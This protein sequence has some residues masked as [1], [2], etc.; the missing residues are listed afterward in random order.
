MYKVILSFLMLIVVA[1]NVFSQNSKQIDTINPSVI[2]SLKFRN[3]SPGHISGRISDLAVNPKNHSEYYVAVSSG[4]VWKTVNNG[5]TFDPIFDDYGSFSMGCI[6]IDPNNASVLWLGTGENTHQRSVSYG[7]GI[8]KSVDAGKSWTNMGLKQSYQIGKIIVHPK[9]S[10]VVFVACEGSVWGPGGERGVYKT[11][12]GGKTWKRTLFVSDNTG[13]SN[14]DI[15]PKD[16]DIMYASAEQRRRSNATRIGG[17]PESSLWKSTDGGNNWYKIEKGLPAS[18]KGGMHIAVSPVDNNVIYAMVEA[19]KKEGGF[20]RS[21]DKGESW[22]KMSGYV[23]S[24]Q[25]YCEFYPSPFDVNKIYATETVSKFSI[26]GGKTWTPIGN[27]G[28]HVDD[29]T[30]W[31]DNQDEMHF[32][33]GT[34][35][36]LYET[37]DGGAHYNHKIIPVTQY[38]R[39]FADNSY[40]FYWVYGGTQDNSSMGAPSNTLYEDGISRAEWEITIGGDG[41]WQAVD[42]ENT[43]IVYSEYQYGNI[44]RYDKKS[45]EKLFVKPQE[46]END[47]LYKWHWDTPFII[48][49]Y[50]PHR[51]YIAGNYLFKSDDRGDS[52]QKISGDLSTGVDRNNWPVMDRYWGIDA[53]EKDVST[54]LYGTAVSL[55]ESPLKD[56]FLCVG[57]NDGALNITE[58][59]GKTWSKIRKI[60]DAPEFTFISDIE[61]SNFDENVIYVTLNNHK[62]FDF[63]PYIFK[64]T[65][66]GKTWKSIA[67]K[68]PANQPLHTVKQDFKK[69]E[70][71]FLGSEFGLYLTL[72]EGK[73]WIKMKS[74]LPTIPVRDITTQKNEEDLVIA[75]FG[76]GFYIL[77]DYSPLRNIQVDAKKDFVLF[78]PKDAQLYVEKDR[79]GYGF[80]SVIHFDSNEAFGARFT[81]YIKDE[82]KTL[83][84]KRSEKEKDLIKNKSKIPIPSLDELRKEAEEVAPY[85]VFIIKD[86]KGTEIR[87]LNT[88]IATGINRMTWDLR[89]SAPDP[90]GTTNGKFDNSS[91]GGKGLLVAEGNY[92]VSVLRWANSKFDTLALDKVFKVKSLNISNETM[93]DKSELAKFTEDTRNLY[94]NYSGLARQIEDTHTK[95]VNL[96]QLANNTPGTKIDIINKI[97]A[98]ELTLND[99]LWQFNGQTPPASSEERWPQPVPLND[100]LNYLY[101]THFG[102]TLPVTT[103]E[104]EAMK[105]LKNALPQIKEKLEKIIKIEIPEIEMYFDKINAPW[106]EGKNN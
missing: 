18:D 101:Y 10:N 15:D 28:R 49:K 55:A 102:S 92:S 54:S 87:K 81:Y 62:N 61:M 31:I 99:L 105:I 14:I 85:L 27:N 73:Q 68:L 104:K 42:P 58:N 78:D 65:D 35:G 84:Q 96:K 67:G 40:P 17:G 72:D 50:N 13:V 74:G 51:L 82:I 71:L 98:T 57:T 3:L 38:Y 33:I 95:I 83:K 20:Y 48:S 11:E 36:G 6:T 1:I 91:T 2:G 8:Y 94:R 45:G 34:D 21:S 76:R 5:T 22:N 9:N 66:K 30:F 103:T 24:G 63:K 16:P 4:G 12:D 39:V 97:N 25:Y 26:D 47:S 80:G 46:F 43:D 86:A 69:P 75:T 59:G 41:F 70:M 7:D 52:W 93:G 77:D 56:G 90:L 29:H 106:F 44:Y 37:Y 64:S 79:G 23:T 53:V 88:A 60:G 89:Y 100:R 32:M 19:A